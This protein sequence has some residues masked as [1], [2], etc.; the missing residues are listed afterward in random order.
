MDI[1]ALSMA[2]SQAN[3]R[4]SV[5][6]DVMKLAMYTGKENAAT[7]TDIIKTSAV[8]SNVGQHFDRRA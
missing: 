4:Q 8:D 1:G 7:M 3:V 5:G 2:M 6:I